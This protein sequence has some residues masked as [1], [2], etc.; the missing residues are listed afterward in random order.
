MSSPRGRGTD[1]GPPEAHS[2]ALAPEE[3]IRF[4]VK[5]E[6]RKRMRGVRRTTPLEACAARS[7]RIVASLESH[8]AVVAAKSVA[9]FWPIV[10]RHEVDL[11]ALDASLLSLI[12][13]SEPTRPY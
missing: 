9:L 11:R 3:V 7:A 4:K 1:P 5:A 10:E 6:L 2:H 12:H 13:I 8:A